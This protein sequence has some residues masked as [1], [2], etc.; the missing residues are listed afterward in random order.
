MLGSGILTV[1]LFMMHS[2]YAFVN[3]KNGSSM[4]FVRFS[5]MKLLSVP[6]TDDHFGGATDFETWLTFKDMQQP[7]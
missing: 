3:N 2:L 6:T 7:S 5:P 4:T 1:P